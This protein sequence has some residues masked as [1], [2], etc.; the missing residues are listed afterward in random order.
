MSSLSDQHL[1]SMIDLSTTK[2]IWNKLETFNEGDIVVKFA[3]LEGYQVIYENSKMKEDERING[4]MERVN[5]I[6]LG[7]QCYGGNISEEEVVSKALRGLPLA[8]KMKAAT[9]N[10]L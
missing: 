9:I 4:F 2:K 10:E 6:V 1:I 8:Y 5:E 7:I 3:K